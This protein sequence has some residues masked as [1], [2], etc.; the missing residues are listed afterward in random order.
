MARFLALLAFTTLDICVRIQTS[1]RN[2]QWL[3]TRI[4]YCSTKKHIQCFYPSAAVPCMPISLYT[5]VNKKRKIILFFLLTWWKMFPPLPLPLSFSLFTKYDV[6]GVTLMYVLLCDI[7]L[8]QNPFSR[9][10]LKLERDL[11]E[12]HIVTFA[13]VIAC[14]KFSH[15]EI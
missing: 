11:F 9:K 12:L 2:P 10:K 7:L 6:M 4:Q 14:K 15:L 3:H 1:I 8:H 5:I 13:S